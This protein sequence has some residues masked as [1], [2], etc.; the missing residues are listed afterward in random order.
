VSRGGGTLVQNVLGGGRRSFASAL[1][2]ACGL[3]WTNIPP[4]LL[5]ISSGT[6]AAKDGTPSAGGGLG[7]NNPQAAAQL[8]PRSRRCS[9][10]EDVSAGSPARAPRS[11]D[12]KQVRHG[13]RVDRPQAQRPILVRL[14][15]RAATGEVSGARHAE[16]VA[17]RGGLRARLGALDCCTAP[18][19][20]D[21]AKDAPLCAAGRRRVRLRSSRHA[22]VVGGSSRSLKRGTVTRRE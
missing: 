9:S 20:D 15:A 12:R 13:G 21:D 7:R 8:S 22:K 18:R 10:A 14:L 6:S 2:G 16:S 5:A 1:R 4:P 17:Q 3:F 19:A 11:N